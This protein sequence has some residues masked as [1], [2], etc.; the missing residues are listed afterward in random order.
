M[1]VIEKMKEK[2]QQNLEELVNALKGDKQNIL[3]LILV[4]IIIINDLINKSNRLLVAQQ[5]Y[6]DVF[7]HLAAAGVEHVRGDM[8]ISVPKADAIFMKNS[9]VSVFNS[10]G[11]KS[12]LVRAPKILLVI[13]YVPPYGW[14]III[15][16]GLSK[17]NHGPSAC[18]GVI[19]MCHKFLHGCFA[20]PLGCRTAFFSELMAIIL[21]IKIASNKGWNKVWIESDSLSAI[22]CFQNDDFLPHWELYSHWMDC[23]FRLR[24][25]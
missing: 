8:F 2:N 14:F 24:N 25:M 4:L 17:G 10:L 3:H 20:M 12:S 5:N 7:D 21:A 13:W 23:K 16:N 22:N 11:I 18:G 6:Y 19:R 9:D 1:E 15:M